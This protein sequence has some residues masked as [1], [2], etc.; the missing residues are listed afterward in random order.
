MEQQAKSIFEV[1][2]HLKATPEKSRWQKAAHG[3]LQG[4]DKS[5]GDI[6]RVVKG[7]GVGGKEVVRG[8]TGRERDGEADVA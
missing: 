1:T 5:V 4:K 3:T 7:G 6:E 8:A 2:K